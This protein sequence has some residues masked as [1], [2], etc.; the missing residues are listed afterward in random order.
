MVGKTEE[1]GSKIREVRRQIKQRERE[2]WS[3]S[4]R[5]EVDRRKECLAD[6]FHII[7]KLSVLDRMERYL[8]TFHCL[9]NSFHWMLKHP[10]H[11]WGDRVLTMKSSWVMRDPEMLAIRKGV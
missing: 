4:E 2:R 11:E 3:E 1:L 8:S 6:F 10:H 5:K 7:Y 9:P